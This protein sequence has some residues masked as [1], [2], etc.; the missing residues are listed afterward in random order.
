MINFFTIGRQI[1]NLKNWRELHRCVVFMVRAYLHYFGMKKML[2]FFL[3]DELLK[4]TFKDKL[5]PMEQATR[6]FFYK[7]STFR[8]R[9]DLIMNHYGFLKE[10]LK[11]EKFTDLCQSRSALI[12][13]SNDEDVDWST[14]LYFF[15]GQRKE[16]LLSLVMLLDDKPLYQI[17]FWINKD[18][19]GDNSLWIGAMQG[20]NMDNAKEV[21]KETTKRAYRYRT[22]NLIVYMTMAVARTL[23]LKHIY[24]VSNAGYY[25]MNHV[26]RNRKLKTDFGAFWK[27][28][29]GHV[30][31]DERFY[32]LPMIES[33]KT[34]EE[35]PTRKRAMYRKRFDFQDDVDK[36]IKMNMQKIM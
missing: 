13:K 20:P 29:G 7:N 18:H 22:K 36:Q 31:D 12:W 6:A 15:L 16:G 32:E 3:D 30:T 11:S 9:S 19:N 21:I 10:K 23:E 14:Y 35:I 26:R 28:V 25:A 5:Y 33:R 1:Y 8:E 24:A 2:R 34:P 17:I 4:T 27:E